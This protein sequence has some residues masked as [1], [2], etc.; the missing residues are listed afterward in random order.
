MIDL[1]YPDY[2]SFDTPEFDQ[3]QKFYFDAQKLLSDKAKTPNLKG[4]P[5]YIT[6]YKDVDHDHNI[7]TQQSVTNILLFVNNTLVKA[8]SKRQKTVETSTYG[9]ELIAAKQSTK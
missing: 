5:V 8:I 7:L 2:A 6:V 9:S 4:K 1:H 3:C